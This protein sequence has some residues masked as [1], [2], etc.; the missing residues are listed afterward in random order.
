MK[1]T[2]EDKNS[3]SIYRRY[4]VEEGGMEKMMMKPV[5]SVRWINGHCLSV[6]FLT[7]S[8]SFLKLPFKVLTLLIQLK[9]IITQFKDYNEICTRT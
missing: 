5:K 4:E 1:T 6:T 8:T 7:L 3:A 2:D 9:L